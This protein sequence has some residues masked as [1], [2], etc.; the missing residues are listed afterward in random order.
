MKTISPSA[1]P[2]DD[3]SAVL[4]DVRT[5]AEFTEI[6]VPGSLSVPLHALDPAKVR[7]MMTEKSACYLLCRS[8]GRAQ[9]AAEK[10]RAAG[11]GNIFVVEGGV[12]AWTAAGLPVNRGRATM[13]LERQ[14]R[15][16]AGFLVLTGMALGYFVSWAWLAI[17]AFVGGGLMFSGITDTCGMGMVL[18]R[19]PWNN[20][21]SG[22]VPR[23]TVKKDATTP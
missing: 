3:P 23:W 20:R 14:V 7:E 1:L 12:D 10:L 18:A 19:M 5:P 11:L 6:N 15:I 16:S 13:S 9:Q 22:C 21:R 4:L 8:G 17:S 2:T